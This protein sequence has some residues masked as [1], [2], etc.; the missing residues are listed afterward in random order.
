MSIYFSELI[1]KKPFCIVIVLLFSQFLLNNS[2][3]IS[4]KLKKRNKNLNKDNSL[5]ISFPTDSFANVRTLN[6]LIG[7]SN[8]E[9]SLILDTGS[10]I[11]W[12]KKNGTLSTTKKSLDKS[13]RLSYGSGTV[14]IDYYVDKLSIISNPNI[15][16]EMSLGIET[17]N[18]LDIKID[19]I[20]GL[21]YG[22]NK[23]EYD[24]TESLL[25]SKIISNDYFSILDDTLLSKGTFLIGEKPELFETKSKQGLE[26]PY[27]D[28]NP[29]DVSYKKSM[30]YN[31]ILNGLSNSDTDEEKI[32]LFNENVIIDSGTTNNIV[33][34]EIYSYIKKTYIEKFISS[35]DCKTIFNIFSFTSYIYCNNPEKLDFGKI[36]FVFGKY[37]IGVEFYEFFDSKTGILSFNVGNQYSILGSY[38]FDAVTMSFSRKERKVEFINEFTRVLNK[39][40]SIYRLSNKIGIVIGSCISFVFILILVLLKVTGNIKYNKRYQYLIDSNQG[41]VINN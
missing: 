19:G 8:Q 35:S 28:L 3:K 23:N 7:N 31:C 32:I 2:I 13:E 15:F 25:R 34:S 12:F 37:S 36:F 20:I 29:F 22:P 27:C 39:D 40:Y 6:T 38:F 24:F 11:T 18:T 33:S 17:S 4:Y 9:F 1:S 30:F 14:Y 5:Y 16:F 41:Y 10:H 21:S 26:I